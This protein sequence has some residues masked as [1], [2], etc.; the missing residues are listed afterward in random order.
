[1]HKKKGYKQLNFGKKSKKTAYRC[2]ITASSRITEQNVNL[3]HS[4]VG[5]VLSQ[6]SGLRPSTKQTTRKEWSVLLAGVARFEL[7]N[8]GVKVPCL[9]AWR[10]PYLESVILYHKNADMSRSFRKSFSMFYER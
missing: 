3:Q 7:T 10:Y 1:M 2:L 8:E 6:I 9:T 4:A 5:F